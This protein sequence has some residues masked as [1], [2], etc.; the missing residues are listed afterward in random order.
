MFI[1]QAKGATTFCQLAVLSNNKKLFSV[2]AKKLSCVKE[3]GDVVEGLG[4][5][6]DSS[7]NGNAQYN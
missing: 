1:M 6:I 7:L 3:R 4:V 2:M 5:S